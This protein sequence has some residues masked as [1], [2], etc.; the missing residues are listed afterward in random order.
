MIKSGLLIIKAVNEKLPLHMNKA[1][2]REGVIFQLENL[3]IYEKLESLQITRVPT[4][5]RPGS[6]KELKMFLLTS[7]VPMDSPVFE[8]LFGPKK[9]KK[10]AKKGKGG[11]DEEAEI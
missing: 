6:K 8:R 11:S 3:C 7:G 2:E 1:F 10:A 4:R 9:K 5:F